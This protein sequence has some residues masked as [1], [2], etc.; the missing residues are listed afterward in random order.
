MYMNSP[1]KH[2]YSYAR[3]FVAEIEADGLKF[4]GGEFKQD[5][6]LTIETALKE[7]EYLILIEV[8]WMQDIYR[9]IVL[10][11]HIY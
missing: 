1:K 11:D 10:S 5:Q 8:D 3:L 4:I 6:V 2:A 9:E 7:G